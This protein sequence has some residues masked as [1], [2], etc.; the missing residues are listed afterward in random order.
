MYLPPQENYLWPDQ[1]LSILPSVSSLSSFRSYQKA[2]K[3]KKIKLKKKHT[4]MM[5]LMMETATTRWALKKYV[6]HITPINLHKNKQNI[7]SLPPLAW[8]RKMRCRE[9]ACLKPHIPKEGNSVPR[10]VPGCTC[11]SGGC[12]ASATAKELRWVN[13]PALAGKQS[14]ESSSVSPFTVFQ[15]ENIHAGKPVISQAPLGKRKVNLNKEYV[16]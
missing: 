12:T 4:N 16:F 2:I 11:W 7:V 5:A 1:D 10:V 9:A 14:P 13:T 6:N 15:E 8:S 3:L